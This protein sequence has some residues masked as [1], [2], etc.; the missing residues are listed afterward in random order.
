MTAP[1][2]QTGSP[3]NVMIYGLAKGGPCA[4][5]AGFILYLLIKF[6]LQPNLQNTEKV[7]EMMDRTN[8]SL[9]ENVGKLAVGIAES[10]TINYKMNKT[11]VD[12]SEGVKRDH[13][14]TESEVI[15][16]GHKLDAVLTN[17]PKE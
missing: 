6:T 4:I 10:N 7:M 2:L 12:F 14:R 11:L 15:K 1:S 3:I 5:M 17:M 13:L 16:N 9:S 8:T